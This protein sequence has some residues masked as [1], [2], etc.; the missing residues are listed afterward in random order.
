MISHFFKVL[1]LLLQIIRGSPRL[2]WPATILFYTPRSAIMLFAVAVSAAL[3]GFSTQSKKVRSRRDGEKGFCV[4]V[5]AKNNEFFSRETEEGLSFSSFI[6]TSAPSSHDPSMYPS[7][8]NHLLHST[9]PIRIRLKL[10][11]CRRR[12]DHRAEANNGRR[13]R[14]HRPEGNLLA[15][16]MVMQ[17]EDHQREEKQGQPSLTLPATLAA[18]IK[19]EANR[20]L[21]IV[22]QDPG[23]SLEANRDRDHL[24]GTVKTIQV[25]D[26][27]N[28][29][30]LLQRA[31]LI[32][33]AAEVDPD[34]DLIPQIVTPVAN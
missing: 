25:E 1:Y 30:L 32:Q 29:S 33:K 3:H 20:D 18:T 7:L 10:K 19:V 31:N 24:P 11:P 22:A 23:I 8:Y 9:H 27:A 34:L 13:H 6:S 17:P 14:H 4:T 5:P 15:L 21:E 2:P 28:Q 26:G 12:G 16:E